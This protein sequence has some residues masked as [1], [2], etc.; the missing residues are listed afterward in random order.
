MLKRDILFDITRKKSR[1]ALIKDIIYSFQNCKSLDVSDE[2]LI[3]KSKIKNI[4]KEIKK[5]KY[6]LYNI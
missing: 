5:L 1:I 4:K 3:L 6:D 2:I